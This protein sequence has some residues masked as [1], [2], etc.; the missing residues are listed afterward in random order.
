MTPPVIEQEDGMSTEHTTRTSG[1]T[2]GADATSP[3]ASATER[4]ADLPGRPDWRTR[5]RESRYGTLGV[6]VVTTALILV[7]AWFVR[8]ATAPDVSEVSTT[9]QASGPAPAVGQPAQD[10]TARTIDGRT[11][12][13]SDYRGKPVWL[14]FGASW[15]ASCRAEAPDVQAVYEQARKDG[16]EVLAVY[17]GEDA[18]SVRDY[19]RDVGLTYPHIPDPDTALSGR[20]RVMGI[21]AHYFIAPDGTIASI[22]VGSLDRE[23]MTATLAD[24]RR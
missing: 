16:V 17:L 12:Q 24:L 11:V 13:L 14:L 9:A 21:P 18:L 3:D 5:L 4:G 6:L 22:Q 23:R 19:T 10:F 7:G 1:P 15:C 20:Y 2:P 8:D